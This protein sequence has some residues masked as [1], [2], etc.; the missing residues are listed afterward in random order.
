MKANYYVS[1]AAALLLAA[2]AQAGIEEAEQTLSEITGTEVV[3]GMPDAC[4]AFYAR[5]EYYNRGDAPLEEPGQGMVPTLRLLASI[6]G[7]PHSEVGFSGISR[8]AGWGSITPRGFEAKRE[9]FASGLDPGVRFGQRDAFYRLLMLN[10]P[11]YAVS[12]LPEINI[13]VHG[14]GDCETGS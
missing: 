6:V 13:S 3:G 9:T 5:W 14:P 11:Q 12:Y 4:S 7:G 2:P 1:I 8:D 10:P